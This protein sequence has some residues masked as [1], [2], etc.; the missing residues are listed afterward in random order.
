MRD[1]QGALSVQKNDKITRTVPILKSNSTQFSFYFMMDIKMFKN[2][3]GAG[4]FPEVGGSIFFDMLLYCFS[5]VMIKTYQQFYCC[6]HY[7]FYT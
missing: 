1:G 3:G 2:E 4:G 5:N 7:I 6:L